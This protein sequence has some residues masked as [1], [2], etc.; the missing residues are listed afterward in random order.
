[1][2]SN[3]GLKLWFWLCSIG[4]DFFYLTDLFI[5]VQGLW[6]FFSDC[7]STVA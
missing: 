1:L 4:Y 3:Q 6:W 2:V 7:Q 5:P